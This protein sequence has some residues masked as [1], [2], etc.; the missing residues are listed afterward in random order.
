MVGKRSSQYGGA[1]RQK[2]TNTSP[3]VLA[4]ALSAG[5][6]VAFAVYIQVTH[7][8]LENTNKSWFVSE[9][10]PASQKKRSRFVWLKCCKGQTDLVP[11]RYSCVRT[12][13]LNFGEAPLC[14][15]LQRSS[16]QHQYVESLPLYG[17]RRSSSPS[18]RSAVLPSAQ[19]SQCQSS[20]ELY[21]DAQTSTSHLELK[22][23]R[24]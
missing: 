17:W 12:S 16:A 4:F 3:L 14:G 23:T 8:H 7:C 21:R 19:P 9:F 10:R 2:R 24:P 15:V 18:K 6:L 5:E 13:Y 1:C 11:S 20:M 22:T